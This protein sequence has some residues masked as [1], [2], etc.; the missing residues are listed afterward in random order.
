ML[1]IFIANLLVSLVFIAVGLN[2]MAKRRLCEDEAGRTGKAEVRLVGWGSSLLDE[3]INSSPRKAREKALWPRAWEAHM[4]QGDH[5][6]QPL[7]DSMAQIMASNDRR[8]HP[9]LV[10]SAEISIRQ[11]S[12]HV[13]MAAK[14]I[15]ADVQNLSRGGICIRTRVPLV[16]SSAVQCQI[17]VPDVLFAIPTLMQVVWLEKIDA[18]EFSV[19][20]RYLF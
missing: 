5:E 2:L 12:P 6:K 20:L 8:H 9:R 7:Q 19:G 10:Q 11:L 13:E 3:S 17:G 16:T 15:S 4:N 14:L 1:S 18:S